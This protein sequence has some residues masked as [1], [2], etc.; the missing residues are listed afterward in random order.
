[1][2][3][4]GLVG[5]GDLENYTFSVGEITDINIELYCDVYYYSDPMDTVTLEIQPNLRD[6]IFVEESGGVL[7]VRATRSINWVGKTPV[8]TV[9]S[10]TL[11]S[12]SLLGAG[13]FTANDTII[14]D[15]FTLKMAGAG[16]G[17]AELDVG[18]LSVN[19]TGAGSFEFRGRADTADLKLAGAGTI[20]ALPLQTH[21]AT[22][23][24]SG[25]GIVRLGC[26]ESLS[27]DAGGMGSVEYRGSPNV[28]L[29]KDGLVSVKKVG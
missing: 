6:Y 12:L 11:N 5:V 24:L 15:S 3:G 22:V 9:G 8:L 18:S 14:A 16:K 13:A 23:N 26:S 10:S 25:V 29:N 27:I 2:L 20:D 17:V 7:T 4:G 28:Q 19:K 1:M 21:Y